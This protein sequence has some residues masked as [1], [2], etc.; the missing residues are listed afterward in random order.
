[1]RNIHKAVAAMFCSG[2]F[3]GGLGTGIAFS[4]FSSFEYAGEK[5][6]GEIAMATHDF[7]YTFEPSEDE[8][9]EIRNH[10]YGREYF[11]EETLILDETVPENTVRFQV[12][13]NTKAVAPY[14]DLTEE[15]EYLEDDEEK[16]HPYVSMRYSYK[17]DDLELFMSG[18]DQLLKDLKNRKIGSYETVT[19]ES[20]KVL[21]NPSSS[22]YVYLN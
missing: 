3:L 14:A 10:Y 1:M 21:I 7:D 17:Q 22:D 2:I 19:V 5:T 13:Y 9:L 20:V 6:V 16:T 11:T 12:T 18:K 4:E 8:K 15:I